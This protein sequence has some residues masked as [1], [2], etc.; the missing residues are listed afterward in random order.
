MPNDPSMEGL[1]LSCLWCGRAFPAGSNHPDAR[2]KGLGPH[3][4]CPTCG[5]PRDLTEFVWSIAWPP[6]GRG[7]TAAS[8]SSPRRP[9]DPG[10]DDG[11]ACAGPPDETASV[12]EPLPGH[13]LQRGRGGGQPLGLR[14]TSIYSSAWTVSSPSSTRGSVRPPP[15]PTTSRSSSTS[16]AQQ[17][18]AGQLDAPWIPMSPP[19]LARRPARPTRGPGPPS[20]CASSAPCP[21]HS[22]PRWR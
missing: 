10:P 2:G 12:W 1:P 14:W 8:G 20:R 21:W 11:P 15:G 19:G 5:A 22:T 16:R 9:R 17:Q 18:I 3:G 4:Y 7:R 6:I 13:R